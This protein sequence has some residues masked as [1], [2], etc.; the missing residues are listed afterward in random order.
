M[1][2]NGR[3]PH[4]FFFAGIRQGGCMSPLTRAWA[5]GGAAGVAVWLLFYTP[6]APQLPAEVPVE[7]AL[8]ELRADH[9]PRLADSL[10]LLW[11]GMS[12]QRLYEKRLAA[13]G[14]GVGGLVRARGGSDQELAA[15]FAAALVRAKAAEQGIWNKTI[16]GPLVGPLTLAPEAAWKAYTSHVEEQ[17]LARPPPLLPRKGHGG[18]TG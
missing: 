14:E 15:V 9:G 13:Y 5:W 17:V 2:M 16:L 8:A 11:P 6:T 18:R 4:Q 7:Q 3:P 1:G 10:W 12:F